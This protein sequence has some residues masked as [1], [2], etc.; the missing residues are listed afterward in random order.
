[1]LMNLMVS[2]DEIRLNQFDKQWTNSNTWYKVM[3][4]TEISISSQRKLLYP[5]TLYDM[6]EKDDEEEWHIYWRFSMGSPPQNE[7]Q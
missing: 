7:H 2:L 4:F 6:P 1:M 3:W 5:R